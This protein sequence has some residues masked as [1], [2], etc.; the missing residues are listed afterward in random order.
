MKIR[1]V[2]I[3]ENPLTKWA[4]KGMSKIFPGT[5]GRIASRSDAY[6]ALKNAWANEIQTHGKMITSADKLVGAKY[7]ADA[8]L[9]DKAAK[10]AAKIAKNA[11][12]AA[13]VASMEK[14]LGKAGASAVKWGMAIGWGD[15][16]FEAYTE[17][18][19][20]NAKL[21]KKEITPEQYDNDVRYYLGQCVTKIAAMGVASGAFKLGGAVIKSIP[22][23]P[24]A[25]TLGSLVSGLSGTAA[26]SFGIWLMTAEGSTKFAEWYVSNTFS[27]MIARTWIGG[28][29]KAAYDYIVRSIDQ[30]KSGQ[31][32]DMPFS[33]K[34]D[35]DGQ[36]AFPVKNPEQDAQY[37]PV[38]GKWSAGK[39]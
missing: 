22:I 27:A 30:I 1:D 8:S 4:A 12:Y 32:P 6:E 23:L 17:I 34:N 3:E 10:E 18:S 33:S 14:T 39:F 36:G 25:G 11:K 5:A 21:A 2:I 35:T 38:T 37:N 15:A 28:M 20:L 29:S 24:F 26:A 7:A 9:I 13:N 19:E 31:L 16:I